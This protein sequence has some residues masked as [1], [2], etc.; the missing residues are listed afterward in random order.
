MTASELYFSKI[1]RRD[2]NFGILITSN[3]IQY[4][5]DT[6][7]N[8]IYSLITK[9]KLFLN[10]LQKNYIIQLTLDHLL[11]RME[12]LHKDKKIKDYDELLDFVKNNTLVGVLPARPIVEIEKFDAQIGGWKIWMAI[13]L[14]KYLVSHFSELFSAV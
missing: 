12:K 14:N 11:P 7:T 1:F 9:K 3:I 5:F 6:N 8:F 10:S 4:Q 13:Y 2:Q